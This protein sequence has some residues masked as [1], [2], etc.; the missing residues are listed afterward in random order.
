[1]RGG[2][3]GVT[4]AVLNFSAVALGWIHAYAPAA[5]AAIALS[6]ILV[7]LGA[8]DAERQAVW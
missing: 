5:Q 3:G 4:A 1:M 2:G 7:A 8:P 6:L